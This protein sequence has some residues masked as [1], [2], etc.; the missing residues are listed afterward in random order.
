SE[1]NLTFSVTGWTN[2]STTTNSPPSWSGVNATFPPSPANYSENTTYQFNISWFDDWF[3]DA[4]LFEHNFTGTFANYSPSGFVGNNT[5]RTYFYNYGPIAAGNYSWRSHANDTSGAMNSTETFEFVVLKSIPSLNITILP[6]TTVIFGTT[7]NVSCRGNAEQIAPQLARNGTNV[8]NPDTAQLA[9]GSYNYTCS[10]SGNANFTS[11]TTIEAI[12]TVSK[13]SSEVNLTINS[14]DGNVSALTGQKLNIT[15]ILLTPSSGNIEVFSDGV[16]IANGSSPQSILKSYGTPGIVN[17]TARYHETENHT[18]SFETHFINISLDETP[19]NITSVNAK[20]RSVIVGRNVTINMTATDNVEID[21][22]IALIAWPNSTITA[23]SLPT[24][25]TPVIIGRHN[26]TFIT[27]DTT[28]NNATSSDFFISAEPFNFT[29][30][31]TAPNITDFRANITIFYP[32]SEEAL[33]RENFSNN[34]TIEHPLGV[35]DLQISNQ[36]GSIV[37]RLNGVNLSESTN[38]SVGLDSLP[39][40]VSGYIVSYGVDSG[41]INFTN[42]TLKLSYANT[43]FSLES[44]LRLYVCENWAFASR[45]CL[46]SFSLVENPNQNT[47]GDYFEINRTSFSGFS[48]A[49][50]T[51]SSPPT[52]SGGGGRGSRR[53]GGGIITTCVENWSCSEWSECIPNATLGSGIA[54]RKCIDLNRCGTTKNK[55]TE[56]IN[57]TPCF[58]NWSCS[59]WSVCVAANGKGKQTRTC[60]ATENANCL[61]PKEHKPEEERECTV[62]KKEIIA[63]KVIVQ[64]KEVGIT[65]KLFRLLVV[66]VIVAALAIIYKLLTPKLEEK[67]KNE[68]KDEKPAVV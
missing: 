49:E 11:A 18:T 55:P 10:F 63:E 53:G 30:N 45:T 65:N 47:T 61:P 66:V 25:F 20:P 41:G 19:P 37:L 22:M 3:L 62:E 13:A 4:V 26:V 57:C 33:V 54:S 29:L 5:N 2:Y 16:L 67:V 44:A 52:P 38:K 14:I 24:Q 34:M 40:P 50:A 23:H 56:N 43:T 68:R 17:V 31:V 12:L 64:E 7:T 21:K 9:A 15:A 39:S 27:N 36:N 60:N 35:Y 51:E 46:G 48:I 8:G 58:N 1:G 59:E 6:N 28:G 32:G 42:A